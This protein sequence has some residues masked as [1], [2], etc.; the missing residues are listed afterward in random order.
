MATSLLLSRIRD[1]LSLT[2]S[3]IPDYEPEGGKV[4]VCGTGYTLWDD[5]LDAGFQVNKKWN[6]NFDVMAVNRSIMDIPCFVS[7]GYSNHMDALVR[8]A[9]ARDEAYKHRDKGGTQLHSNREYNKRI[10]VWTLPGYG[11]SG[12]NAVFLALLLGYEEIKIAGMP[13]DNGPHYYDAPYFEWNNFE[14]EGI[15]KGS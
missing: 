11:T 1:Y 15:Y 10:K 2:K 14:N 5:L 13:I 9:D 3:Q 6:Q 8:W 12:L 7:H 4:V